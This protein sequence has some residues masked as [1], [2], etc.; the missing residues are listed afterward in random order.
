[1]PRAPAGT[2]P[3]AARRHEPSDASKKPEQHRGRR[4]ERIL[5]QQRRHGHE[6][7]PLR[8]C[9]A[10]RAGFG[11]PQGRGLSASPSTPPSSIGSQ[12]RRVP[13]ADPRSSELPFAVAVDANNVY[14]TNS[15][16]GPVVTSG[17]VVKQPLA[18]EEPTSGR[19]GHCRGYDEPLLDCRR[20]HGDWSREPSHPQVSCAPHAGD[21][22]RCARQRLVI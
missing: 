14:W 18:G 22:R 6:G 13:T 15:G 21:P 12:A 20:R 11:S 19:I 1:M 9:A 5:G 8:R 2:V 4:E 16:P 3:A 17:S 7:S 10:G